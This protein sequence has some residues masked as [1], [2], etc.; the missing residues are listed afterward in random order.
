MNKKL[1]K[2]IVIIAGVV[3]TFT[4]ANAFVF[5]VFTNR[6]INYSSSQMQAKSVEVDKFLP[7]AKETKIV[8]K[9]NADKL[10]GDLPVIDAAAALVP[11]QSSIVYSLYP[12]AS[13]KYVDGDFTT[14][15]AM[16][17]HNTRGAFKGIADGTIDIAL[18][19]KPNK[20]QMEYAAS[21]GVEFELTPI[22]REAFVF[23]INKNNKVDNLTM[24]QL[25]DIYK[26]KITNW[27][28]VGGDWRP[29]NVIKRNK[30]SGSQ[31][32]LENLIG[33]EIKTNFFGP[34][35]SSLGF[36]FRYYVEELTEHGHIKMLSLN[37]V[38][39]NKENVQNE[40]Y[41]IISNFY[42]VTRKGETNPNVQ[43]I[44]DFILS[45]TGQEIVNEVGYVGLN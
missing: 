18:C 8:K 2:Q 4:I 45:P 39:P 32:A 24:D 11:I 30:G 33:D 12:E 13:V 19:A 37:G 15:S 14:D 31:T 35:G 21:K 10:Q 5:A 3:G 9:E 7:F 1:V 36:S 43:K 41:P 26:G 25:K 40:S 42:A 17:Y 20:E 44:L 23:I 28:E 34:L 29:I 27:S 38:Y 16:Q 22:G 6:V